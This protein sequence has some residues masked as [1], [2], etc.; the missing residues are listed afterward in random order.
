MAASA[1]LNGLHEAL[2]VCSELLIAQVYSR[3]PCQQGR[4]NEKPC[5]RKMFAHA[6]NAMRLDEGTEF[7]CA[8]VEGEDRSGIT[9]GHQEQDEPQ[10]DN[11]SISHGQERSIQ[12]PNVPG[13][14]IQL[15]KTSFQDDAI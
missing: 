14:V 10:T 4:S 7:P 6:L 15:P 12:S 5:R 2:L 11:N 9:D 8:S 1:L 13:R 3:K